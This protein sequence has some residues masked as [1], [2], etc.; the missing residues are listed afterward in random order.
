VTTPYDVVDD[1]S[2]ATSDARAA[3]WAVHNGFLGP[4][5]PWDLA[6]G[7]YVASGEVRTESD[8]RQA[9]LLTVRGAGLIVRVDQRAP[10]APGFVADVGRVAET[11]GTAATDDLPLTRDQ[12]RVLELLAQGASI[13]DAAERLYLSLRTANRRLAEARSAL[14]V[15]TTREAVLRYA[16]NRAD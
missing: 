5:Q 14:Q 3:G 10:W 11:A 4:P 2:G 13:A 15:T 6:P 8:A 12:R 9:L 16:R 1:L 7:R